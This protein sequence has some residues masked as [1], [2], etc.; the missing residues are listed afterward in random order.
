L[1]VDIDT[2]ANPAPVVSI[3]LTYV[4]GGGSFATATLLAVSGQDAPG[5]S[6][7]PLAITGYNADVIIEAAAPSPIVSSSITD[8]VTQTGGTNT[9]NNQLFIAQGSTAHGTYNLSNGEVDIQSWSV[10][11]RNGGQGVFNMT[12]G[13]INKFNNGGN[14]II[15]SASGDNSLAGTVG[16]LNQSSGTINCSSEYWIAENSLTTATNNISGNAVLNLHN[17]MSIGRGGLGVLNIS[18]NATINQDGNNWQFGDGGNAIIN[19]SG[20]TNTVNGELRVALNSGKFATYN[21]SGGVLNAHNWFQV[22]RGGAALLNFTGGTINKDNNGAFII[23]DNATDS[24]RVIQTGAGTLFNCSNDYWIGNNAPA[25]LDLTNGTLIAN[26]LIDGNNGVGTF[27]QSGGTV[28]ANGE[29]WVGQAAGGAGS[30][31]NLSGGG[32][33]TVHNWVSIGRNGG[34]GTVNLTSGSITKDN[35]GNFSIGGD[36][37]ATGTLNQSAGTSIAV[38]SGN[39][40]YLGQG[41]GNGTWNMDGGTAHLG[42]LQFCE[43]GNG[44]GVLN[45]NAGLITATEVNS[46]TNIANSTLNFNGGT[47]QAAGDNAN[48]MHDIQTVNL[49]ST[50]IIDSQGYSIGIVQSLPSNGAAT[51]G[52]TKIGSGTLTLAGTNTYTGATTV[53]NGILGATTAALTGSSGFSVANGAGLAVQ[54]V[55]ALNTQFTVPSLTLAGPVSTLNFDL[56]SFGNPSLAPLNVSASGGLTANGTI[57]VNVADSTPALGQIPL[58]KYAGTIAGSPTFVLGS[59]PTGVTASISNNVANKSIDL[60][61]SGLNQPRWDGQVNGNWDTGTETNWVNIGTQL[62]MFYTDPSLVVF[63]DNAKGT[64]TVTLPGTVNP[65]GVTVNNTNL[66]YTFTGP[67]KISGTNGLTKAGSGVLTI[68]NTN[69]YTGATVLANGTLSVATLAN[70]GLPSPIGAAGASPKNLV[71]AGGTLSYSGPAITLNRPYTTAAGVNPGGF[72]SVNNVTLTSLASGNGGEFQKKGPSTLTY[73]ASGSNDLTGYTVSGSAYRVAAG[74]LVLDGSAG[75]QT[76]FARD[77]FTGAATN[78][79]D[80]T[81]VILTNTTLWV[82]NGVHLGQA[83]AIATM[84]VTN[85]TINSDGGDAFYVGDNNGNPTTAVFN[86]NGS[87][88]NLNGNQFFVGNNA[89]ATATYNLSSGTINVHDWVVIGRNGANGTLNMTGGTINHTANAF[90]TSSANNSV[91][92]LN[93]S[94]GTLNASQYWLSEHP[95]DIGTNNISG[96]AQL[97][98]SSDFKLGDGGLGVVNFTGGTIHK[99]NPDNS[100]RFY[101]GNNNNGGGGTGIFNQGPGTTFTCD[102]DLDVGNGTG[103]SGTYNLSGGTATVGNVNAHTWFTIGRDGGGGTAVYNQSGGSLEA[104]GELHVAEAGWNSTMNISGGLLIAHSWFQIGRNGGG[105]AQ[106]NISGGAIHHLGGDGTMIIG[107]QNPNVSQL[108]QTGGYIT[109]DDQ[110]WIGNNCSGIFNQSGGTNVMNGE[111]WVGQQSGSSEY[112]IS[113]AAKLTVGSWL[114][115]GRAGAT[116]TIN[117]SGGSIT[118]TGT[119]GDHVSVG[120]GG[121]GTINQTGGTFTSVLSDTYLGAGGTGIWNLGPGSVNLS[122]LKFNRDNGS[123]GTMNLNAGGTLTVSEINTNG[124]TGATSTFNFDGGTLVASA[125]DAT[126]MQGLT[127]ANVMAGGANINTGPNNITIA[128]AL[129]DGGGGGLTKIGTGTLTLN[130]VNTFSGTTT[131]SA[132]TLG[133]NGTIAGPVVVAAGAALSPG[134]SIGTLTLG[135]T[136]SLASTSTTVMEVNKITHTSDL[137]TSPATITYGGTLVL[138]N[139]AGTLAPGD[140]FTLFSAGNYGAPVFSSVVSQTPG[141]TVTWDISQLKVNGTVKVSTAVSTAPVKVTPSVVGGVF[142]LSWPQI[143]WQLELQTNAPTVGIGTNWV[144]VPGSTATNQMS[145]PIDSHLGSVFFRLI[146]P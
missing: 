19:Q 9:I 57:T 46:P 60:V 139:M 22:G 56:D 37:G 2:S 33:I 4:S 115:V 80:N 58:V 91:G 145:F 1:S 24:A 130:G 113:G 43:G 143:G 70:S 104:F 110:T 86:Q 102:S 42:L 74:A 128:Q 88:V 11:G 124:A 146:F 100:K 93:L 17:W 18:G 6:F 114:P 89:N 35:S 36:G 51:G 95:G 8:T 79:V 21:M 3:N 41:S 108:I 77:F 66:P 55:G 92:T 134:D 45:F 136:L 84:T 121:P 125:S 53:N 78:A 76:N 69:D 15:G 50:A 49:N 38:N 39:V 120:D 71:F 97:T 5:N 31:Y 16:T 44:S 40:T 14:F 83:N 54:V 96:T 137:V 32:T 135:S 61:I 23:A 141:Q 64:T 126:F 132:G 7:T 138:R 68:A 118:K 142:T 48:F 94:G 116:G 90:I 27:N 47:L 129:S 10:I 30:I 34:Q 127:T 107:D 73:T 82:H 117:M 65:L 122:V 63:D 133:G 81:T 103:T 131:V 72:D 67:G 28:T 20:G 140:T 26:T 112:D 13:T 59:L 52:L 12:G 25:E 101:V 109:N 85:S 87:T 75:A 119:S 144:A 105:Q 29:F 98:V 123:S 106:L 62:P 111:F 99:T